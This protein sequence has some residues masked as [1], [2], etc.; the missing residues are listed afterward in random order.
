MISA[1]GLSNI[2]AVILLNRETM[3]SRTCSAAASASTSQLL[4]LLLLL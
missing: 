3:E 2:L 1:V 4:L